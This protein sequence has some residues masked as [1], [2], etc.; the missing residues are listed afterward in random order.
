MAD[1]K[2]ILDEQL[3]KKAK[4]EQTKPLADVI[5]EYHERYPLVH[6]D[7]SIGKSSDLHGRLQS[8]ALDLAVLR[9]DLDPLFFREVHLRF[10]SGRL[11]QY[12]TGSLIVQAGKL[13]VA[14][15]PRTCYTKPL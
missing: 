6:L 2:A 1:S 12:T 15:S 3:H 7:I 13:P 5:A 14:F 11:F 10:Q 8:G 4:G 9:G